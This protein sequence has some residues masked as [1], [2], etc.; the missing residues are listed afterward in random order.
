[1]TSNEMGPTE[2]QNVDY[3][4]FHMVNNEYAEPLLR[5]LS[6]RPKSEKWASSLTP[7]AVARLLKHDDQ[8]STLLFGQLMQNNPVFIKRSAELLS[9]KVS[10]GAE[11]EIL[12]QLSEW[13]SFS[14]ERLHVDYARSGSY[15]FT[16]LHG[17]FP[18]LREFVLV[19]A[20]CDFNIA[21]VLSR[22][23]LLATL[24][25]SG[26]YLTAELLHT[27]AICKL[28]SLSVLR[29]SYAHWERAD[30]I[31][32][33]LAPL[34]SCLRELKLRLPR[35]I[36]LIES[37]SVAITTALGKHAR[38]VRVFGLDFPDA[39]LGLAVRLCSRLG[40]SLDEFTIV[41]PHRSFTMLQ[42]RRI[43]R[44]CPNVTI[45]G[46][47]LYKDRRIENFEYPPCCELNTEEP[48]KRSQPLQAG[49]LKM[50]SQKSVFGRA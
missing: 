30:T 37:D 34:S 26:V 11:Q 1:M 23:L 20:Y 43:L 9:A 25:L 19:D 4:F 8:L 13:L 40:R 24:D 46:P 3:G 18:M 22:A 21:S 12:S 29:V 32:S 33:L 31:S 47:I 39:D 10:T 14:I 49:N 36:A 35:K 45:K 15:S 42:L 28:P 41:S 17:N 2:P 27:L 50:Q 6:R 48:S 38:H 5:S 16:A 44:S 7:P